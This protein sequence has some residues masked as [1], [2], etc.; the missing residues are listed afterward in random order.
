M[1]EIV[2]DGEVVAVAL[3]DDG[4]LGE[5]VT[6]AVGDGD[7][8]TLAV[9]DTVLADVLLELFVLEELTVALRVAEIVGDGEDVAVGLVLTPVQETVRILLLL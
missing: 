1:A 9:C 7:P 6:L 2:G 8:V 3:E 5:P 4:K